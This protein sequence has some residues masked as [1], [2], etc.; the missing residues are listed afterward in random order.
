MNSVI[1]SLKIS[2]KEHLGGLRNYGGTL[3]GLEPEFQPDTK[4][5]RQK[6]LEDKKPIKL[7]LNMLTFQDT[8][9]LM[10]RTLVLT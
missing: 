10:F 1:G 6:M 9:S 7:I 3:V 5:Q 8:P 2:V 4:K